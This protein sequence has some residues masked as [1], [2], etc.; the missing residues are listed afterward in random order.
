MPVVIL[1]LAG[2]VLVEFLAY[3]GFLAFIVLRT[4]QTSGL[5]DVAAA[6]KA[7]RGFVGAWIKRGKLHLSGICHSG[8]IVRQ[9]SG[10]DESRS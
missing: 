4:G 1:G 5:R 2:M 7:Y 3:L 8:T 10:V 6:M 9:S